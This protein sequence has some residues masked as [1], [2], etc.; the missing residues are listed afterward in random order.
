MVSTLSSL[1][2]DSTDHVGAAPANQ[3]LAGAL[4]SLVY[5]TI[6]PLRYWMLYHKIVGYLTQLDDDVLRDI[7][8]RLDIRTYAHSRAEDRWPARHSLRAALAEVAAAAC[9]PSGA[10]PQ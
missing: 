5:A 2:N 8:L 6:R 10:R 9:R 3:E 4:G 7:G 1:A